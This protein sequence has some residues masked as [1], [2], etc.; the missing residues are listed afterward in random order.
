GG[1]KL[2]GNGNYRA[3]KRSME[4]A[5]ALKRK[6]GFV[7]SRIE[8]DRR[9]QKAWLCMEKPLHLYCMWK[10]WTCKGKM[11]DCLVMEKEKEGKPLDIEEEEQ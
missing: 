3:W 5:L 10:N 2:E 6:L 7:T 11:L 1:R 9:D 8:K 4:I